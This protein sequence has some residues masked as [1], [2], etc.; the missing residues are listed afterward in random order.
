MELPNSESRVTGL[1]EN[2]EAQLAASHSVKSNVYNSIVRMLL[3]LGAL[4]TPLF[5]LPISTS[6]LELNKQM[7]LVVLAGAALVI[8]LLGIV[9]S[10]QMSVRTNAIDKGIAGILLASLIVTLFSIAKYKS[11]FG[12]SISLSESL[13]TILALSIFYFLA[14]NVFDDGGR[15]LRI[16]LTVS[17]VAALA[18]GLLQMFTVYLLDFQF[19]NSR[20]FNTVGSLNVLGLLAAFGLPLFIKSKIL[21]RNNEYLDV[22]KVGV[23]LSLAIL[24]VLNWWVLWVVAITAMVVMI[25]LDSLAMSTGGRKSFRMSKFILPMTVIVLGVFL[26]IVNFNLSAVKSQLP[27]EVAPSYSL[28]NDVVKSVLKERLISGYGPENFSIAF[29]KYGAQRLS[30]TT[31]SNLKFFDATSQVHNFIVHGG[32]ITIIALLFFLW[33]VGQTMFKIWR[34]RDSKASPFL[35]GILSLVA[36][37]VVAMFLYPFNMTLMFMLYAAMA[38]LVLAFWGHKKRVWDIEERPMVSLASSLGFIGGLILVLA[39]S[40]FATA[41][42]VSDVT[43]AKASAE[44]NVETAVGLYVQAINWNDNNDRYYR[45]SSQAALGLLTDEINKNDVND[46]QRANRIQNFIASS[47]DLA[48]RAT[49]TDPLESNNWINLGSVY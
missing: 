2:G 4:L 16:A 10:G 20:A 33:T 40:Y 46:P 25:A 18:F 6:I 29:D 3:V 22:A 12:A 14:V 41:Q 34:D 45:S 48:K 19:S 8:W 1:P 49:V 13:A 15:A 30:N 17:M 37:V 11:L 35:S 31:L 28:S 42:Y 21:I 43:F 39:G 44:P 36:A 47:I 7:L 38:L 32:L 24:I 27:V 26:L 23:G 5:F 9:V